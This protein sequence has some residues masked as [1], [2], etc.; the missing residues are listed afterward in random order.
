MLNLDYGSTQTLRML[1]FP[2][3]KAIL[4][5]QHCGEQYRDLRADLR[6][7]EMAIQPTMEHRTVQEPGVVAFASSRSAAM[8]FCN[9][10]RL[11]SNISAARLR[12]PCTCSR[13]SLM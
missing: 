10:R 2:I 8:R 9:V 1:E 6:L 5:P 12:L 7:G 3:Q 13:V 4:C 11:I